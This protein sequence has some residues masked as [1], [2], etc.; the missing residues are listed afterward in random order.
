MT[1]DEL[2]ALGVTSV[3]GALDYKNQCIGRVTADGPALTPDGQA[4]IDEVCAAP[5]PAEPEFARAPR[6]R[7]AK[8]KAVATAEQD[9]DADPADDSLSALTAE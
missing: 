9:P 6:A 4:L 2:A 1:F 8:T 5:A 3:A 7:V